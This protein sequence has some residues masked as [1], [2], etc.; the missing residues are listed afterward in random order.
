MYKKLR[1]LIADDHEECRWAVARVLRFDFEVVGAVSDGGQLVDAAVSLLPDVIVSDVRMPVM[2]GNRA[3]DELRFKG[4][5]IPFV[6][7]S[8]DHFGAEDY[9]R[10]GAMAFVAKVDMG[11]ALAAAVSSVYV[12]QAYISRSAARD[13]P[14]LNEHRLHG[15]PSIL[16]AEHVVEG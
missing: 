7:I 12:G 13:R 4:Y 1:V 3:M 10:E 11:H 8:A 9:I 14:P 6:L 2:A 16:Q 15:S 5:K